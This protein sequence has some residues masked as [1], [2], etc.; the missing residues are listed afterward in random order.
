MIDD[1]DSL[2]AELRALIEMERQFGLQDKVS[3]LELVSHRARMDRKEK[4]EEELR[5]RKKAS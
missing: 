2:L 1:T 3:Q 5:K 4:I